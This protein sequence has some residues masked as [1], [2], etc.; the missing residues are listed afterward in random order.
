M[1]EETLQLEVANPAEFLRNENGTF[2]VTSPYGQVFQVTCRREARMN[3]R[4]VIEVK[5]VG[6]GQQMTWKIRRV[7]NA[8]A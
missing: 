6:N 7:N 4:Q 5:S 3:V 2:E 8:A 1:N